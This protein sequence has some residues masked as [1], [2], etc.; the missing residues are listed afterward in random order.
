M[1]WVLGISECTLLLDPTWAKRFLN[2]H[3]GIRILVIRLRG[4]AIS[5]VSAT[6]FISLSQV[7]AT[8]L[9]ISAFDRRAVVKLLPRP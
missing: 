9:S 2:H 3:R 7:T 8:V 1:Y 6:T 4:G 5:L